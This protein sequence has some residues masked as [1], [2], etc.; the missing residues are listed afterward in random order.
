MIIP[1]FFMVTAS[2]GNTFSSLSN[3]DSISRMNSYSRMSN[4]GIEYLQ[5]NI[6]YPFLARHNGIE[7]KVKLKL[8]ISRNGSITKVKTMEGIGYGCEEEAV[9]LVLQMPKW[10]PAKFKGKPIESSRI[11][12]IGFYLN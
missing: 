11:I 12:L 4:E 3:R 2:I 10:N 8:Y 5:N 7:G 9:R 6:V 1:S